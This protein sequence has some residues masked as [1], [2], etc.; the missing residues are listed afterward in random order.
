[1]DAIDSALRSTAGVRREAEDGFRASWL[2]AQTTLANERNSLAD[3]PREE[4]ASSTS[5]TTR[6]T[7][8]ADLLSAADD[9]VDTVSRRLRGFPLLLQIARTRGS[10]TDPLVRH[11]LARNYIAAEVSRISMLRIQAAAHASRCK[12]SMLQSAPTMS[13]QK[14]AAS[15]ACTVSAGHLS[16]SNARTG[17]C[18][19]TKR[20][21]TTAPSRSS[22]RLT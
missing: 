22:R 12:G 8:I 2:V 9:N 13:I 14:L 1:M 15:P 11:E 3:R 4:E 18:R 5:R 6:S 21:S 20:C 7:R 17:R 19:A 10:T 16:T